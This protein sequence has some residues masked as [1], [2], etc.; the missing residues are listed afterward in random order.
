MEL[1][2]QTQVYVLEMEIVL[3]TISVNALVD[4]LELIVRNLFVLGSMLRIPRCAHV[5]ENV[6]ETTLVN[7]IKLTL[8]NNAKL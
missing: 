8:E 2:K 6:L 1:M 5:M 7:V 4:I 3:V